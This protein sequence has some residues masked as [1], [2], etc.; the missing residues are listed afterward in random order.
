MYFGDGREERQAAMNIEIEGMKPKWVARRK[1]YWARR[2]SARDEGAAKG[3]DAMIVALIAHNPA[4][5]RSLLETEDDRFGA[6]SLAD[7][8]GGTFMAKRTT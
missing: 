3:K 4:Y 1:D 7:R 8:Y 2:K 6:G 5:I